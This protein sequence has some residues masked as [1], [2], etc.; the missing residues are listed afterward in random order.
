MDKSNSLAGICKVAGDSFGSSNVVAFF[1]SQ[2]S[3]PGDSVVAVFVRCR[4]DLFREDARW[5]SEG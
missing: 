1:F 5:K 3:L 2:V 4:A